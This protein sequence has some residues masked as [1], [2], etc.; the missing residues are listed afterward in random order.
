MPVRQ[1]MLENGESGGFNYDIHI[2]CQ[3]LT[4]T[5]PCIRVEAEFWYEGT[6]KNT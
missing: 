1:E 6:P 4:E 2:L 3:G 5:V